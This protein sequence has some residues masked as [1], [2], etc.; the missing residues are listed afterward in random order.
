MI[1]E[2]GYIY[3]IDIWIQMPGNHVSII[4]TGR[5][6]HPVK[7]Y[8]NVTAASVKRCQRAQLKLMEEQS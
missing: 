1:R 5:K 8:F 4:R 3:G 7:T 2:Y 6:P